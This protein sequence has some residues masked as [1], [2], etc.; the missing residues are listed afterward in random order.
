[1]QWYG[2]SFVVKR[3]VIQYEKKLLELRGSCLELEDVT[4]SQETARQ[5]ADSDLVFSE[6]KL[7]Y[8]L[9]VEEVLVN[10]GII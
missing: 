5:Q 9:E 8:E 10:Y 7:V 1:M 2:A 4:K 6:G 3:H